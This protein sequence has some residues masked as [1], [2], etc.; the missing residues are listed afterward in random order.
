[1]LVACPA[2]FVFL[3]WRSATCL[4]IASRLIAEH[5]EAVDGPTLGAAVAIAILERMLCFK[6][7][8]LEK[9][10]EALVAAHFVEF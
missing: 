8:T 10:A 5:A 4:L 7:L 3:A 1:M 9:L 2:I 6:P